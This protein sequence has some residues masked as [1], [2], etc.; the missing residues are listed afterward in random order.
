MSSSPAY[1]E[2]RTAST[3][4]SAEKS[5]KWH[6]GDRRY[7]M[8]P[9]PSRPGDPPSKFIKRQFHRHEMY[10]CHDG[11][12]ALG[13]FNLDRLQ[14][15]RDAMTFVAQNTTIPVPRVLDWS[16]DELGTASL[17]METVQG[18]DM[19]DLLNGDD[20][21]NQDKAL[22]VANVDAFMETIVFPQLNELRSKTMGQLA[23]VIFYPP[24][25][26]R[27]FGVNHPNGVRAGPAR[28]ASTE[29]YTFCHN[30]LARQ[31]III[32]SDSLEVKCIIDWE[33]AGFF[34][35]GFEFPY[36]RYSLQEIILW[37]EDPE[38]IIMASRRALVAKE[39]KQSLVVRFTI[40]TDKF[41]PRRRGALQRSIAFSPPA[42]AYNLAAVIV[43]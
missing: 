19:D 4:S 12:L 31:N 43:A 30:D 20:L 9:L 27:V 36:W 40:N 39:R 37:D 29:R 22:L 25:C 10:T 14:N 34:P 11:E 6:A 33:Y 5:T 35:P 26:E 17:T 13:Y 42:Y 21:T 24:R 7:T 1:N 15:E 38:G 41:W 8:T 3:A 2:E 28:Q 32:A 18:R 16:V 23:G